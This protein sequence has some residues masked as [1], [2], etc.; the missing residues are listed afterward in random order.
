MVGVG[1]SEY[2]I[3]QLVMASFSSSIGTIR[4]LCAA[5]DSQLRQRTNAIVQCK[6][7]KTFLHSALRALLV[8]IRRAGAHVQ[9]YA[10]TRGVH[11]A[12]AKPLINIGPQIAT[13]SRNECGWVYEENKET[14][15]RPGRQS[16]TEA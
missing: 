4:F 14:R 5:Y 16:W 7:R 6:H 2:I 3:F 9:S 10:S 11:G 1:R 13:H 15:V 12:C 8:A